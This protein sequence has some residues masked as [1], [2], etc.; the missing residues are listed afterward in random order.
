MKDFIKLFAVAAFLL[1]GYIAYDQWQERQECV[2]LARQFEVN[3]HSIVATGVVEEAK[4]VEDQSPML[5][6][7]DRVSDNSKVMNRLDAQC[8]GWREQKYKS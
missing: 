1:A 8:P 6:V 3:F 2:V 5:G 4:R 7:A